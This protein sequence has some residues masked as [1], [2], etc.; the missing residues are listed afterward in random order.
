MALAE[1]YGPLWEEELK[2]I[3]QGDGSQVGTEIGWTS[4]EEGSTGEKTGIGV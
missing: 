2:Y 1:T 3:L 4:E